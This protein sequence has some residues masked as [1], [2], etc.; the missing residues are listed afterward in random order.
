MTEGVTDTGVA[1]PSKGLKSGA[2]GFWDGVS[3]G[4]DSTAPA[5]TIAAVLGSIAII[6]GTNACAMSTLCSTQLSNCDR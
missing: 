1:H 5:Y 6:A 2:V 3:I 4:V